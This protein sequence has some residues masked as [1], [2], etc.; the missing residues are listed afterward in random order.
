MDAADCVTVG[1]R[2]AG[3]G[4]ETLRPE[5]LLGPAGGLRILGSPAHALALALALDCTLVT[6]NLHKFERVPGLRV[7]NWL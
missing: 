2:Q 3:E 1:G 6:D 4:M 5:P 7:E